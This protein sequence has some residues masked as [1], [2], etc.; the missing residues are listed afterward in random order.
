MPTVDKVVSVLIDED[1]TTLWNQ[2][3]VGLEAVGYNKKKGSKYVNAAEEVEAALREAPAMAP[4]RP[5]LLRWCE[6]HR[7]E[8]GLPV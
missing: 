4:Y 8:V 1:P 5:Y 3:E 2:L 6:R 7:R